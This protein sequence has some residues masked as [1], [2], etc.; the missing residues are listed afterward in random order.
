MKRTI[1]VLSLQGSFSSHIS[2][3]EKLGV[4]YREIRTPED[5]SVC[6]GLILPG[7]ESTTMTKLLLG[8]GTHFYD[9]LR[10][11]AQRFPIMGTCAG[12]ILLARPC[13]DTRVV[14][15][16][17]LPVHVERNSYGRQTESFFEPLVLD[18]QI[19]DTSPF[20]A[21][22]IRAPKI[23]SIEPGV[24]ILGRSNK[25]PVMVR[26]GRILGLTFH[27][28]LRPSDTRVHEYFLSL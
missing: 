9:A 6:D 25:D 22:F 20:P 10:E 5:L 23:V 8:Y 1:G 15:L 28:E 7:G 12:L 21:T 26:Y 27:P 14:S 3:L 11:F 17:I 16:D 19:K 18:L 13:N 4:Q 24:S 2:V